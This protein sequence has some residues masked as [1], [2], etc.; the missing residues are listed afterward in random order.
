MFRIIDAPVVLNYEKRRE[1]HMIR[2]ILLGFIVI[3]IV[4]LISGAITMMTT[5]YSAGIY[6]VNHS[7]TR[8]EIL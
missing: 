2:S 1:I 6:Q 8:L 5:S 3:K 7:L 4:A